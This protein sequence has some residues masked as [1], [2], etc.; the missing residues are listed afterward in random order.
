VAAA[1][2]ATGA[3]SSSTA[4]AD[5]ILLAPLESSISVSGDEVSIMTSDTLLVLVLV[6]V[7][8]ILINSMDCVSCISAVSC[9]GYKLILFAKIN[10]SVAIRNMLSMNVIQFV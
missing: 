10:F 4:A 2:A 3:G 1:A 9:I 5:N 8:L 6:L 7:H